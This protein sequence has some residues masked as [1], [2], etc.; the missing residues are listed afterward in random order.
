M[1][2]Q[3]IRISIAKKPYIFVIFQGV[4]GG[5]GVGD[6]CRMVKTLKKVMT[7][8]VKKILVFVVSPAGS[9][10]QKF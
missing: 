2:F 10:P 8:F 4:G 6:T 5:G 9:K 1:V 7:E 3:G